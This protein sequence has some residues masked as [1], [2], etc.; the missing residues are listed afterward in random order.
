MLLSR[1]CRGQKIIS[2]TGVSVPFTTPS[3][4]WKY[5]LIPRDSRLLLILRSCTAFPTPKESF[6]RAIWSGRSLNQSVMHSKLC[7]RK[8]VKQLFQSVQSQ[9]GGIQTTQTTRVRAA[10]KDVFT[11]MHVPVTRRRILTSLRITYVFKI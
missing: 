6:R 11:C 8:R 9:A 1:L 5:F 3:T 10:R 7:Q 4:L 2:C